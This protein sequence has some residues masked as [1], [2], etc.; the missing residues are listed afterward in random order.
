MNAVAIRIEIGTPLVLRHLLH[1]DALLARVVTDNGGSVEDL[2]LKRTDGVWHASAAF[3]ETGPFGAVAAGQTRLKSLR[4]CHFPEGV[5]DRCPPGKRTISEMS[6]FRSRLTPYETL[7]GAK[8]LW[9]TCEGDVGAIVDLLADITHFGAYHKV[10]YGQRSSGAQIYQIKSANPAG[11]AAANGQP[12]RAIP[13]RIWEGAFGLVRHPRAVV[14]QATWQPDYRLSERCEC[15]ML[16]QI[17]M[18]GTRSEVMA[19]IGT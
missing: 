3:V 17:D 11:I 8:A 14:A 6:V 18:M 7:E 10:G 15:L 12:V 2:P 5:L 16:A 4:K 1:L 13:T 19:L 9:W